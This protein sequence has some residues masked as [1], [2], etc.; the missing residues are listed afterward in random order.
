VHR[1]VAA[2]GG[3][4]SG[5]RQPAGSPC[6]L[7]VGAVL[8]AWRAPRDD[9]E[10]SWLRALGAGNGSGGG[11]PSVP[12]SGGGDAARL[13]ASAPATSSLFTPGITPR[14]VRGGISRPIPGAW[15]QHKSDGPAPPY[16]VRICRTSKRPI[17]P[18]TSSVCS[19]QFAVPEP[20]RCPAACGPAQPCK[21]QDALYTGWSA[22]APDGGSTVHPE[23]QRRL[24]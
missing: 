14:V 10:M 9:P 1:W 12:A 16:P 15:G 20:E 17:R 19:L 23:V 18:P 22:V 21:L 7:L 6:F 8:G 2:A 13:R 4:S 24:K 11:V 3:S 5:R